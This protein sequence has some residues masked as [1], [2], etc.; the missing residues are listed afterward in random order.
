MLQV[1]QY[2]PCIVSFAD[3]A[4][5]KKSFV[6]FD[7]ENLEPR[8]AVPLLSPKHIPYRKITQIFKVYIGC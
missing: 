6:L 7:F 5:G 4:K 3:Y 8:I 1:R 2:I